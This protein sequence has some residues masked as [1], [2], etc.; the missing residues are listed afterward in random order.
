MDPSVSIVLAGIA[1]KRGGGGGWEGGDGVYLEPVSTPLARLI[2][3]LFTIQH[4]HHQAL[5]GRLDRLV[6]ECLDLVQLLAVHG[7]GERKL[8]LD[9]LEGLVQQLPALPKR[10]L[11]DRLPVQ[12]QQVEG[13]HAHFDFDIFH[14]H[15]LL[16]PRHELL[17][18]QHLLLLHIPCYRLAVQH[19]ALRVLLDPRRE[20]GEDVGVLLGQ[21][22]R[23]SREDGRYAATDLLGGVRR[24]LAE[25]FVRVLGDVVD[26]RPLTVILVLAREG[27]AFEAVEDFGNGLGRFCQ[28]GFE[29]DARPQLAVLSQVHDA[30]LYHRRDDDIVAW[31]LTT[32]GEVSICAAE[33]YPVMVSETNL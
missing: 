30:V 11:H 29:G 14:L 1:W 31:Q 3:A 4:L 2:P 13:K 7:R 6:E 21:V 28:H 27:L 19:E 24:R 25:L 32:V 17:E 20:L 22:F 15:V 10:L 16:L 8:A 18:G 33:R 12:V 23:V 26:L 5:A 9:G